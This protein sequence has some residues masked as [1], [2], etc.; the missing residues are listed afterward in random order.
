MGA[1]SLHGERLLFIGA[2]PDDIELG[3]GAT[4]ARVTSVCDVHCLTLSTRVDNPKYGDSLLETSVASLTSLGVKPE[5]IHFADFRSRHFSA[6]RQEIDDEL[7]RYKNEISADI[8]FAH[9][10]HDLHQDHVVVNAE[11]YRIFRRNILLYE[12]IRSTT[13]LE[14]NVLITVSKGEAQRKIDALS[15]YAAFDDRDYLCSDTLSG[16]MR[17]RGLACDAEY[18]EA[19]ESFRLLL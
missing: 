10:A 2:H 16:H 15:L 19:F 11:A 9:S 5:Q 17:L 1:N 18:A 7:M 13:N 3:C 6:A 8:V 12:N 14:P 4:L